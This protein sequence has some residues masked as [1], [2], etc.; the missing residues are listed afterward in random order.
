MSENNNTS[1]APTVDPLAK[2]QVVIEVLQTN[3]DNLINTLVIVRARNQELEKEL[4]EE[5]SVKVPDIKN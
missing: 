3:L 1:V 5:R 2:A 4:A